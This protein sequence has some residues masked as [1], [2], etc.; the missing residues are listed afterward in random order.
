M[1]ARNSLFVNVFLALLAIAGCVVAKPV[2]ES[3]PN[4]DFRLRGKIGLHTRDEAFSASFDWLQ[5]GD[6]Y[7]IEFWGPLGQ[8]RARL[9]GNSREATVIDA[10]GNIADGRSP[11]ALMTQQLGWSAP[12]ATLRHWVRGGYDPALAATERSYDAD[13]TL[14]RFEQ[15]G[16]VVELSRWQDSAVGRVPGRIVAKQGRRRLVVV[17]KEWLSG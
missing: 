11:E 3:V 1:T 8:G 12:V 13:G 16:W 9:L 5:A 4:A 14:S 10:R 7:R 6:S 17:C 15:L 2:L